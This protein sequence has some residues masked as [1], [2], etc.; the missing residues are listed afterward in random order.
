MSSSGP[1]PQFIYVLRLVP[2]LHVIFEAESEDAARAF[3][4]ADPA[5]V[6]GVMTATMHPYSA[7]L[8]GK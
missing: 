2:R 8:L 3:M 5:I 7:A 6:A 4:Q 1:R